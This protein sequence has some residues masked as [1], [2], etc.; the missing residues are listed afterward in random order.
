M[1]AESTASERT[2]IQWSVL[3]RQVAKADKRRSPSRVFGDM[4][5]SGA[6]YRWGIAAS[7]GREVSVL[8]HTLSR[9]AVDDLSWAPLKR[10]PKSGARLTVESLREAAEWFADGSHSFAY[11]T[12]SSLGEANERLNAVLWAGA[13]PGLIQCLPESLWW[14]VLGRLQWLAVTNQQAVTPEGDRGH[15]ARWLHA[16]ELG[17]TL[18]WRL[19]AVPSCA[20][21]ADSSCKTLVDNLDGTEETVED[22]TADARSNRLMLASVLRCERLL[23]TLVKKRFR[24]VQRN[25]AWELAVWTAAMTR[26]DGTAYLSP[27]TAK[28]TADDVLPNTLRVEPP[29]PSK[30]GR[31]KGR[32]SKDAS[33]GKTITG[34][35]A[36]ACRYEEESLRPAFEASLGAR[37]TGGRLAWEVSLPDA[38]WHGE[39][40]G[41][42]AMMPQWDVRRGRTFLDYHGDTVQIDLWAGRRAAI[43]GVWETTVEID[44]KT[45]QPT[46]DWE[47]SC[48]YTDD[49]VH[50]IELHQPLQNNITL[51]R[52]VMV[53]RDDRCV[54]LSD[55]VANV[56]PAK[57][58][59]LRKV[60]C[61][62]RFPIADPMSA[63]EEEETREVF[64]GDGKRRA[65]AVP[66]AA[67]EWR[68]GPTRSQLRME[69][70][71]DASQ[72]EDDASDQSSEDSLL[73]S[74]DAKPLPPSQSHLALETTGY[75]NVYSPLWLDFQ[76]RRFNRK[77]TWRILTV[78]EDLQ[79]IPREVAAA[80][81]L[82]IGSEHWALYRSFQGER[83]RTFL[84]KNLVA[85]FFAARFH[86]G[87]GGM[88]ELVT[89]DTDSDD[90][91]E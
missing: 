44:G 28:Q 84:G 60:R 86:P 37:Q 2:G 36:A 52:Q 62:S 38:M 71:P 34:L 79:T 76:A 35:F 66:L 58:K 49:D 26:H 70:N 63:A 25:T 24:K 54:L 14:D 65:M 74:A 39:Q 47:S 9:M 50:Y 22:L 13:M 80:F 40:S 59:R 69:P 5:E 1:A 90:T 11:A 43:Q 20:R 57:G 61:V 56:T 91:D 75:G 16:A 18:A 29:R 17:M 23:S 8:E 7:T 73:T 30:R 31:T 55:A 64:L 78:G 15:A 83:P 19:A 4:A 21:L 27:A 72:L 85:D 88:E 77:R 41:Q 3:Q 89:V 46:G 6:M 51:Q 12:A 81:R 48:E 87:D 33:T 53:V 10:P 45:L 82:Q 67:S 32:S 68:V 42:V